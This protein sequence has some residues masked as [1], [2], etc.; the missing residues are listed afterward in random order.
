M[1]KLLHRKSASPLPISTSSSP[2]H[3]LMAS[4]LYLQI[5]YPNFISLSAF[6]LS[7]SSRHSPLHN[8]H[9]LISRLL[10]LHPNPKSPRSHSDPIPIWLLKMVFTPPSYS[11]ITNIVN[12]FLSSDESTTFPILKK[13]Y[14]RQKS[15]V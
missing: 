7:L 5:K 13:I 3:S 10:G 11:T 9:N 6:S 1:N 4:L 14:F 12:L 15:V 2:L 8:Q